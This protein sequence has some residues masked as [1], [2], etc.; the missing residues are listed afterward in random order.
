MERRTCISD[1]Q[2]YKLAVP[3]A[4]RRKEL[5]HQLC[6]ISYDRNEETKSEKCHSFS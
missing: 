3:A 6:G 1:I 5:P 4:R 2:L